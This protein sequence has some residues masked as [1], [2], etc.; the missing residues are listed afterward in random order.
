[1]TRRALACAVAALLAGC[2]PFEDIDGIAF[3]TADAGSEDD[4]GG[5]S[6]G[7]GGED[8]AGAS[9]VDAGP[10][11]AP[12]GPDA[13]RDGGGAM[14]PDAARPDAAPPEPD[15]GDG[16]A[17]AGTLDGDATPAPDAASPDAD[18]VDA[19]L[20]DAQLPDAQLPD[21]QLPDAQLPDAACVPMQETCNGFDDDCDGAADENADCCSPGE[22]R[23]C[24]V[25]RGVCR[26]AAQPCVDFAWGPCPGTAEQGDERCD[27]LD[28]DCDGETDE[29]W[30]D[31]GSPCSAG[32]G[33]CRVMGAIA[34]T[35]DGA[36]AACDAQPGVAGVK[37]CNFLDDDCDG[38]TDETFPTVALPCSVGIGE[39]TRDGVLTCAEDASGVVCSATPG[40]PADD[41]CNDLDDDCDG[42]A[43]EDYA[44]LGDVCTAGLGICAAAGTVRCD[45]AGG[46]V[47]TADNPDPEV[48]GCNDLDDDCDGLTDEDF[49]LG[50]PCVTQA[51]E[52]RAE[53]VWTCADPDGADAGERTCSAAIG[54]EVDETC[55]G[56]DND[57]DGRVDEAFDL[58]TDPENCG[59]C[60]RSCTGIDNAT[61]TCAGG[62]CFIAR[63]DDFAF[64][65]DRFHGNGCEGDA[66]AGVDPPRVWYVDQAVGRPENDGSRDTPFATIGAGIDAAVE[67]DVVEVSPGRY[68]EDVQLDTDYVTVRGT[69]RQQVF[70]AGAVDIRGD[71]ARIESMTISPA[72]RDVGI[73][74]QCGEGCGVVDNVVTAIGD[75][76]VWSPIRYGIRIRTGDNHVVHGNEVSGIRGGDGTMV[77]IC[78]GL[79]GGDATGIQLDSGATRSRVTANTIVDVRAG[80]G[81]GDFPCD[82]N[83]QAC[84]P[85]AGHTG[86]TAIGVNLADSAGQY[87]IVGNGIR[88][89]RGGDGGD[90]FFWGNAGA[91]ASAIG[92]RLDGANNRL[93]GNAMVGLRGGPAGAPSP[94][95]HAAQPGNAVGIFLNV[96]ALSVREPNLDNE[97][98]PTNTV[99]GEAIHYCFEQDDFVLDGR[100]LTADVNPTNLGK[101]VVVGCDGAAIRD[102]T[103]AAFDGPLGTVGTRFSDIRPGGDAAG[104]LIVDSADVR[105]TGSTIR[106]I[107]G[108][109]GGQAPYQ[110][111]LCSSYTS[112]N[113]GGRGSGVRLVGVTDG[114]LEDNLIQSVRGG[115]GSPGAHVG[116]SGANGGTA[117]GF[118]LAGSRR[119]TFRRNTIIDLLGGAAA[120]GGRGPDPVTQIPRQGPGGH[121]GVP[122]GFYFE[123][124]EE[125]YPAEVDNTIEDTNRVGED[126][127]IYVYEE[128]GRVVE[129]LVLDDRIQTFNVSRI[130]VIDAR[131]VVIRN[132]RLLDVVAEP[133]ET[134]AYAAEGG[135]GRRAVGIAALRARDL[136]IEG[137]TIDGVRGGLG[138]NSGFALIGGLG[139]IGDGMAL[140]GCDGLRLRGNVVTHIRAGGGGLPGEVITGIPV[141]DDG[142]GGIALGVYAIRSPDLR[143]ENDLFAHI[144]DGY[145]GAGI[146]FSAEDAGNPGPTVEIA[147]TTIHDVVC[148]APD[149]CEGIRLDGTARGRVRS[150]IIAG[151]TG[152]GVRARD[153]ATC[154]VDYSNLF[155]DGAGLSGA[156]EE[157]PGSNVSG[158]P[159]FNDPDNGFYSLGPGS[160]SIDSGDPNAVCDEEPVDDQGECRL[161]QGHLGNTAGARSL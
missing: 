102:T 21:A 6:S 39:C 93:L 56:W 22:T 30:E 147:N 40:V 139:G 27:A 111:D 95:G 160:P 35:P 97:I 16:A 91:G 124:D 115:D 128:D 69:D 144:L 140:D 145:V 133:G 20:P 23:P 150:S 105:V 3:R 74:M 106:D 161:D 101:V 76:A 83:V 78:S 98:A 18:V 86:G 41:L 107:R 75:E 42:A 108:G 61:G 72:G 68:A 153:T 47:C 141:R 55:D 53:G 131:D 152:D 120:P 1:M 71:F 77:D 80:D 2:T 138:G 13:A 73:S 44:T 17:D 15:A 118:D 49:A 31:L 119:N 92:I 143:S 52:C 46:A 88:S 94:D 85:V 137:N 60:G 151:V 103:I 8:D 64:D 4:G 45:D 81:S 142:L 127:V 87:T 156:T 70:I 24:G 65:L 125:G 29:V 7:G 159:L 135:F 79:P 132:N 12:P 122:F 136:T 96:D 62:E 116:G 113:Q 154:T 51:D 134:G 50:T 57:C 129:D 158:D 32:Q 37:A 114:L 109:H 99:D 54:P 110:N 43:D 25:D 100:T 82:P 121:A 11:A 149:E 63:C 48:E 66:P 130:L 146:W 34:C 33:E 148:E 155:V 123:L 112:G 67:G 90:G 58:L 5:S 89:I 28:N 117:A 59:Q 10:D 14:S 104:L 9:A 38:E 19:Q 157:I 36:G 126:P 84:G 26:R